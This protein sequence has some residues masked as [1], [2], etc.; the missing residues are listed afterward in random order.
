MLSCHKLLIETWR[1]NQYSMMASTNENIFRVT[2]PLWGESTGHQWIPLAKA[3]DAELRCFF[4]VRLNKRFSKQPRR[5]WFETPSRS[6]WLR[7]NVQDWP[8]DTFNIVDGPSCGIYAKSNN[9]GY[10]GDWNMRLYE[11]TCVCLPWT[12]SLH[13]QV[14]TC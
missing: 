4:D 14:F 10:C 2:D 3:S 1:P 8:A 9:G 7:C 6:L 13:Y 12:Y 5:R 11:A